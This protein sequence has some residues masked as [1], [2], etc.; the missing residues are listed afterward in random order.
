MRRRRQYKMWFVDFWLGPGDHIT[1]DYIEHD[2][3]VIMGEV[4]S[5]IEA[6]TWGGQVY[7]IVVTC[8]NKEVYSWIRP[9]LPS[10]AGAVSPLLRTP[11]AGARHVLVPISPP[12]KSP[13]SL[14]SSESMDPSKV[15]VLQ[16]DL[17]APLPTGL[18]TSVVKYIHELQL[19]YILRKEEDVRRMREEAF[20]Y[21]IFREKPRL[22]IKEIASKLYGS[23][24]RG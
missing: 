13:F 19:Q 3:N 15:E 20:S 23:I 16:V 10:N 18:D 5:L 2:P 21:S 22:T 4:R 7:R 11:S 1:W 8:E 14:T 17:E 9:G 6:G 24:P 12:L